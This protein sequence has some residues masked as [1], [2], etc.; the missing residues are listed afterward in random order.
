ML[1]VVK[2][3]F[4]MALW[5]GALGLL[6][7]WGLEIYLDDKLPPIQS[8]EDYRETALQTTRVFA[9]D[10]EVVSELF[11]ERRTLVWG[12]ALPKHVKLAAVAAE[13]GDF[14][15]H[16]GLDFVGMLRALWVNLRDGGFSQGA[17]TISQQVARSF[18]LSAEKT[19]TRKL[20]EVFLARKLERHLDKDQILELYLNQIYFGRGR[21]GV[22]EAALYY[23]GKHTRELSVGEA[24]ML[25]AVL[26]APE[27]LNPF[28]DFE[29]CMARRRRIIDDM[30]ELGFL[31]A[32]GHAEA[33][34]EAPTLLDPTQPPGGQA[35]WFVDAVRRRLE[36]VVGIRKL[37]G[38]GLRIYTSLRR[39]AQLA[40]ERAVRARF[41]QPDGPEVAIVVMDPASREVLGLVGG[42]DYARSPYNRAMQARRQAG[43]IFKPF[44]Y[45]AG[46]ES[47]MLAPG[48][49]YPNKRV[50]YRGKGGWWRPAN[51]DGRHGGEQVT[52]TEALARSLNVV[53]VQALRDVGIPELTDFARRAGLRSRIPPDLTAALGSAEVSPLEI[54][55]AYATFASGGIAGKPVL[56]RRVEDAAGHY[57]YGETAEKVRATRPAVADALTAMLEAVVASG[58]GKKAQVPG[59]VVSGKTGTTSKQIDAWFVGY[60][61]SLLVS[62]WVGH[63]RP[64]P[65]GGSGGALAAPIFGEVVGMITGGL[66]LEAEEARAH[67]PDDI[68]WQ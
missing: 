24:A 5:A 15:E 43:S 33:L 8:V 22:E 66:P 49:T 12:D 26:P 61:D 65:L 45:G 9:A 52:I 46:L 18:Y 47:G 50:G 14:Y 35:D 37:M 40:A 6:G 56:V 2:R 59:Q 53:A 29:A 38:G 21:Y 34:A 41:D 57:V 10:G 13:D 27:R 62:V 31:D 23:L 64:R 54:A 44:V 60:T 28:V 3:L 58:T 63:D 19:L 25:M 11:I 1:R 20:K 36:P 4:V 30:R 16:E 7:F 17:S 32:D 55:N 51:A 42:T 48:K 67:R 68:V 39:D